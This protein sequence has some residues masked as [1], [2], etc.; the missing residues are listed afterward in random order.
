GAAALLVM[1]SDKAAKLGLTPWARIH[2]AVVV[3]SDPVTMLTGPIPATHQ[4][5]RRSGLTLGQIGAYEVNE[6]FAPVPLAWMAE[7]GASQARMNPLGGAIALGHP[8]G[9]T[10]ARLA[11]TLVHHM[12]ANG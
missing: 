4:A 6:A 2:T 11:T 7:T 10:G 5:L 1:S 8:L 3:G 12:R 9:A